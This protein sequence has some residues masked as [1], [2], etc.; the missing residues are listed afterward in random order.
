[1]LS[2]G[3]GVFGFFLGISLLLVLKRLFT[4]IV[5]IMID[6]KK[7]LR[8]FFRRFKLGFIFWCVVTS[9]DSRDL[10]LDKWNRNQKYNSVKHRCSLAKEE[11]SYSFDQCRDLERYEIDSKRNSEQSL[12]PPPPYQWY[13]TQ[14][15][16]FTVFIDW[17]SLI[18]ERMYQIY[19]I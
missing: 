8:R 7:C 17:K 3:S 4:T 9:R 10:D 14:W 6:T 12:P 2:D 19:K 16:S 1:M 11:T 13:F 5:K 18:K 15:W